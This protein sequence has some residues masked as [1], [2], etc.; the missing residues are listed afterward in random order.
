MLP[1]DSPTLRQSQIRMRQIRSPELPFDSAG[2]YTRVTEGQIKSALISVT[3]PV[4]VRSSKK[5]QGSLTSNSHWLD[6]RLPDVG[7]EVP[8]PGINSG[9]LYSHFSGDLLNLLGNLD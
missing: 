5:L 1:A 2:F 4:A 6:L 3:D 9:I 8:E 7:N